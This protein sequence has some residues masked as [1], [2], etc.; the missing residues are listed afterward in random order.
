M[1][2]T[3]KEIDKA[4]YLAQAVYTFPESKEWATVPGSRVR[5]RS[6]QLIQNQLGDPGTVEV[7]YL[8][9]KSTL[10]IAYSGSE[11][12]EMWHYNLSYE[13]ARYMGYNVHE[14][15]LRLA[16]E[17]M[18]ALAAQ[19]EIYKVISTSGIKRIIHCG[20]SAGGA[21]AGIMPLLLSMPQENIVIDFGCP[22]YLSPLPGNKLAYPYERV[23]FVNDQ[24]L[25]TKLPIT[26][27][28]HFGTPVYVRYGV[29]V[30]SP[31]LKERARTVIH[32]IKAACRLR[33]FREVC[34]SHSVEAYKYAAQERGQ[35]A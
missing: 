22:K 35:H 17:A 16:M 18:N 32:Y 3:Q 34:I 27:Y 6:A 2:I 11:D 8:I 31:T 26:D 14:G 28:E 30:P 12:A 5:V 29:R 25:V 9:D 23:R 20:H 15:F 21:V 13:S 24:D 7:A 33:F 10:Y 4:A 1:T 19:G